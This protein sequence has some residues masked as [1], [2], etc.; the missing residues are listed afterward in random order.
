MGISDDRK[1]AAIAD[2]EMTIL[3]MKATIAVLPFQS[4]SALVMQ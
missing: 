4:S 1:V 2:D 3:G